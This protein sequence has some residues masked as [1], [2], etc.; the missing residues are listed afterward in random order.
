MPGGTI[1]RQSGAKRWS[2]SMSVCV[3][4]GGW[5]RGVGINCFQLLKPEGGAWLHAEHQ[6]PSCACPASACPLARHHA[7]PFG[8]RHAPAMPSRLVRSMGPHRPRAC[9]GQP[10][11]SF[12]PQ[13]LL[14]ERRGLGWPGRGRRSSSPGA[15][16][17]D[18]DSPAR[19]RSR[20]L[21]HTRVR[22][23]NK[24]IELFTV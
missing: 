22:A 8:H 24:G 17:T 9:P 5:S 20:Q 10:S 4:E 12:C 6:T 18:S 16:A 23:K 14:Q 1:N 3:W 7:T 19:A 2:M 11:W 21:S 13:L 15:A